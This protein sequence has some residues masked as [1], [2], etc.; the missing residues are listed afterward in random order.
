MA[1]QNEGPKLHIDSDWKAEVEQEKSKM[2][3]KERH[4]KVQGGDATGAKLGP[5]ELP[6]ADFKTLMSTL[7]TPAML[8]LGGIP[9]P[10]TGQ[11]VVSLELA[12]HH[13]DLLAVLEDKCK[14]SLTDD[15]AKD[16]A[17]II[18]ELRNRYVEISQHIASM[19]AQGAPAGT[20]P[21]PPTGGIQMP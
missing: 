2:A 20:S 15:E 7:V 3:E 12:R 1:E 4:A 19:P 14:G 16:L 13:I 5:G 8:Y 18:Y 9:D 10:Q 17:T 11:A 6:P 21:Q